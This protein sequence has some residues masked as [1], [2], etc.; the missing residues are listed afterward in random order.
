MSLPR[1]APRRSRSDRQR[2]IL[3][4]IRSTG[5]IRLHDLA[6]QFGVSAETIRRDLEQLSAQGLVMR[7]LGGATA[8]N[9]LRDPGFDVRMQQN[10]EL[11]DRVAQAA[12][13]LIEPG[14]VLFLSSGITALQFAQHLGGLEMELTVITTSVRVANAVAVNPSA[15]IILAPG[16]FDATEQSVTGPETRSFLAKFNADRAI[17]GASGITEGG[18]TE[19]RSGVAWNLRAMIEGA[20][21]A[22]LLADHSRFGQRRLE[23]VVGLDALDVLVSDRPPEGRLAE[24]LR[25]A[26]VRLVLPAA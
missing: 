16:D 1:T 25:E 10:A 14:D 22:V 12:L 20:A 26:G 6:A 8:G 5:A 2:E 13:P 3:T 11:R 7:T 9:P 21:Q 4:Q 18:V 24:A 17:F 15:Q 23:T 19:S